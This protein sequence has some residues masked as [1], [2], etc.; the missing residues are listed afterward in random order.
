MEAST[1]GWF[2]LFRLQTQLPMLLLDTSIGRSLTKMSARAAYSTELRLRTAYMRKVIPDASKARNTC[3][4]TT[5][6]CTCFLSPKTSPA[7]VRN[8]HEGCR[9]GFKEKKNACANALFSAQVV[10][11]YEC[12]PVTRT[13]SMKTPLC[14][15]Q[16]VEVFARDPV[17][18][19]GG[20][21][22]R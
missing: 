14:R 6:F 16:K 17:K 1:T 11:T 7:A 15:H 12:M 8:L 21:R 20:R 22:W 13:P 9:T 5:P 18:S 19:T 3:A 4:G 2:R 10:L